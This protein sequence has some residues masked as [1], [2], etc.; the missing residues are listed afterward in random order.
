MRIVVL[1]DNYVGYEVVKYLAEARENVVGLYLHPPE[2]RNYG[3]EIIRASGLAN[4][5]VFVAGST[6]SESQISV[7]EALKPSHMLVV[8]W[9]YILPKTV[10]ELPEYGAM[11]FHL[12]YLPFNRGKK[13]NVWPIVE[14][15]PA[16]VSIHFID[17][18]IDSGR[19]VARREVSV[20]IVDTGETL[21][22][23]L[24][25]ELPSLFK[26]IWPAVKNGQ[27]RTIENVG[28]T[29]HYDSHFKAIGEIDVTKKVYPLDLINL[30]RAKTFPPNPAAYF[31]HNGRKVF[32]RVSLDV[33][34]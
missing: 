32:V 23:K 9:R 8:S 20:D 22:K 15:T 25:N 33:E 30:L 5:R 14:G 18:G 16:G 26:E 6:W 3:D 11:N 24:I 19:I 31:I 28:G 2:W 12:S 10:F 27:H 4:E 29:F 7:L 1:A 34:D 17:S 21:Y 13:P